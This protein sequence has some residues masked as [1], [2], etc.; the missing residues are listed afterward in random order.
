MRDLF[1][2]VSATGPGRFLGYVGAGA[3]AAV[4]TMSMAR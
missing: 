3:H 1:V 2:S 4:V